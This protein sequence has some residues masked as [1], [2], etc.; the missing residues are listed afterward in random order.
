MDSRRKT[1]GDCA[2]LPEIT[3]RTLVGATAIAA[4]TLSC[5]R[6]RAGEVLAHSR[7]WLAL[8]AELDQLTVAWQDEEVSLARDFDWLGL[9]EPEQRSH[10]EARLICALGERI[11]VVT[12]RRWDLLETLERSSATNVHDVA[13]KLAVAVRAM[14]HEDAIGFELL[15]AAVR[16]FAGL[17]CPACGA[18]LM[19]PNL[20][21]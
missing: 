11:T 16:E 3:R 20:L 10:P 17:T 18:A 7:T 15:A 13:G 9:P 19:P 14:R 8:D 2:R 1:G 6:P 4:P 21:A 12:E 5:R